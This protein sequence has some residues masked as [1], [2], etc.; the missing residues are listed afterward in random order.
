MSGGVPTTVAPEP[1]DPATVSS[2]QRKLRARAN[3]AREALAYAIL[4][5][6][7][8]A[9]DDVD[10]PQPLTSSPATPRRADAR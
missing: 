10:Q 2:A 7:R 3:A 9:T 1:I 5:S 6:P 4:R 8:A